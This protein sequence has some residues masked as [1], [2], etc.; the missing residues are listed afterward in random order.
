M[1]TSQ[2][3]QHQHGTHQH[4]THQQG[5]RGAATHRTRPPLS[6]GSEV[7]RQLGRRRTVVVAV[8]VVAL[9][10]LI[11]GA[12][13]L[14]GDDSD[15][16]GGSGG[17]GGSG[18]P[19]GLVDLATSSG[20]NFAVFLLLAAGGFLLG[21]VVALFAGDSVA[22][23][24]SWSTLRYLLAAP[25]PRARLLAV[26]LAVALTSGLLAVVLLVAAALAFGTVFYG[27]GD[28]TTLGGDVLEPAAAVPRLALATAYVAVSLLWVAAVA[29]WLGTVTDAALGAVGGAV[30]A[31][32]L[33]G[34]LDSITALGDLRV[35]LPTHDA[36]AWLGA[37]SSVVDGSDMIRGAAVSVSWATIALV[38]AWR[39]FLR[40][41]ITS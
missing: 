11:V 22:S 7:A 21:V 20:L 5:D 2:H 27:W 12:F 40:K 16:S 1:S 13:A 31:I 10:L 24:A 30:L 34:I 29:F 38:A 4:G 18:P 19:S 14:G 17:S 32:I 35:W 41:D 33:S 9:P 28:L 3:E 15:A 23:E 37:F 36:G 25:V 39:A 8:L 6:I 26:K